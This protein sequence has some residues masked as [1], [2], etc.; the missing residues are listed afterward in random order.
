MDKREQTILILVLTAAAMLLLLLYS[1]WGSPDLYNNRVYFADNQGVNFNNRIISKAAMQVCAINANVGALSSV[2]NAPK[3]GSIGD[4]QNT[5]LNV[6]DNYS[7][8]KTA[9]KI[10]S[11][12]YTGANTKSNRIIAYNKIS[13]SSVSKRGSNSVGNSETTTSNGGGGEMSGEAAGAFTSNNNRSNS[14]GDSS[15]QLNGISSTSV[16]LSLFSDSTAMQATDSAQK[17]DSD[18]G[19]NPIEPVPVPEGWGFL[20]ALAAI[21]IAIKR[22]MFF[23]LIEKK[24]SIS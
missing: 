16:D 19:D 1:P 5:E 3:N 4:S 24:K 9:N 18:P 20:L 12:R 8:R 6:P 22:K 14:I 10:S 17:A 11:T 21:Y 7:K 13:R 15:N 23:Q 2:V